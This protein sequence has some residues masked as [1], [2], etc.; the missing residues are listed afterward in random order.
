MERT[1]NQHIHW[2]RPINTP[3]FI[4]PYIH[5]HTSIH[6]YPHIH[7]YIC[8]HPYVH[9]TTLM[10]SH[11][12]MCT[13]VFH[14]YIVVVCPLLSLRLRWNMPCKG[15]M[16]IMENTTHTCVLTTYTCVLTTYTCVLTTYTCVLTSWWCPSHN[17]HNHTTHT[18][19]TLI[20]QQPVTHNDIPTTQHTTRQ[21]TFTD[22]TP[23]GKSLNTSRTPRA[24]AWSWRDLL[25]AV[26]R[27]SESFLPSQHDIVVSVVSVVGVVGVVGVVSVVSVVS[28]ISVVSVG[29]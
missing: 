4:L 1:S 10:H 15:A 17:H 11:S 3:V 6:A 16:W 14:Q 19:A 26:A 28:V 25:K 9:V 21:H 20:I 18:L 7:T 5:I 24:T 22:N 13:L 23:H 29:G 2:G 8:T 27:R 12:C